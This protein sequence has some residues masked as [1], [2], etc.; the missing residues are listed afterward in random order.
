MK[1][2][3]KEIGNRLKYIREFILNESVGLT[4]RQFSALMNIS[5]DKSRNYELGRSKIPIEL[6]IKLYYKGI[7]PIYILTGEGSIVVRKKP[8]KFH[9]KYEKYDFARSNISYVSE[10]N[11]R[12]FDPSELSDEEKV[13]VLKAVA[14]DILNADEENIEENFDL[15]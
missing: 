6:L 8:V 1:N 15:E 13:E 10:S 5:E 4:L 14:G 9:S 11:S 12:K 3:Q 2:L 7:N